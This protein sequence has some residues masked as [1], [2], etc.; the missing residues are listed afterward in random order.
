VI[1]IDGPYES[2][3]DAIASSPEEAAELKLMHALFQS[4]VTAVASWKLTD[5]EAAARLGVATRT[6]RALKAERF[7]KFELSELVAMALRAGIKLDIKLADP[8]PSQMAA[9]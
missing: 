5:S 4:L 2:V 3:W 8:H 9:E 7:G 6:F 1:D